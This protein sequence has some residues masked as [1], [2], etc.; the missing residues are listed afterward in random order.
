MLY[1]TD[2]AGVGSRIEEILVNQGLSADDAAARLRTD[3][4]S[5]CAAVR[6]A[7]TLSLLIAIVRGFGV[8]PTWLLTGEYN[9]HSHRASLEDP[10]EATYQALKRLESPREASR[11]D[12]FGSAA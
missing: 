8:D 12:L 3:Q 1:L 2:R 6:G 7:P 9:Q 11:A 10:F 5:I 4:D